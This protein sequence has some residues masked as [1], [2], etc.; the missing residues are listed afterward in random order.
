MIACDPDLTVA[1]IAEALGRSRTGIYGLLRDHE[2]NIDVERLSRNA[3]KVRL[4]RCRERVGKAVNV[5]A[6]DGAGYQFENLTAACWELGEKYGAH[7]VVSG[8][9][10]AI[11]KERAYKGFVF[12][13]EDIV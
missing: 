3:E 4:D 2:H 7:L 6:P 1:Q 12:R 9:S 13:Y 11:S 10:I 8:A 5:T